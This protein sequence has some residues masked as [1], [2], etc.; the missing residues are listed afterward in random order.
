MS[1]NKERK[2]K[3]FLRK[4]I[5]TNYYCDHHYPLLFIQEKATASPRPFLYVRLCV[6]KGKG[7]EGGREGG[8]EGER[9]AS[10]TYLVSSYIYN[11]S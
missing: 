6:W 11:H 10:V 3:Y 4:Q 2:F 8:K 9:E 1:K 7:R 5:N